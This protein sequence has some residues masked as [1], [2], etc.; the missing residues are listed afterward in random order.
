MS[1]EHKLYREPER[2]DAYVIDGDGNPVGMCFYVGEG[3]ILTCAHVVAEA[4]GNKELAFQDEVPD[5]D[6]S[7]QLFRTTNEVVNA[8]V[9]DDGWFRAYQK[10]DAD[11]D[12]GC[13]D[14]AV[15]E[16]ES[17]PLPEVLEPLSFTDLEPSR[18]EDSMRFYGKTRKKPVGGWVSARENG[19]V[20]KDRLE[21]RT[22]DGEE[23]IVEGGCSG[24][25]VWDAIHGRCVGMIDA[26]KGNRVAYMIQA[27]SLIEACVEI[28]P[29]PPA[30]RA[31]LLQIERAVM[32]ID[33]D[34]EREDMNMLLGAVSQDDPSHPV[35]C[36]I[37][38][39]IEAR[40]ELLLNCFLLESF[41]DGL[42]L[43]QRYA[44]PK[45]VRLHGD[46]D[47]IKRKIADLLCFD[48]AKSAPEEVADHLRN[49]SETIVFYTEVYVDEFSDGEEQ[50]LR[51]YVQY[52]AEI[53][54]HGPNALLFQFF[55]VVTDGP[56]LEQAEVDAV[57][58]AIEQ[59]LSECD[60]GIRIRGP[61]SFGPLGPL[62]KRHLR[63]WV[64]DE[65]QPRVGAA[66]AFDEE[67][68]TSYMLEK[69]PDEFEMN[70]FV[71]FVKQ[72]LDQ[73]IRDA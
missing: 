11:F 70:R 25:L 37:S 28:H 23:N 26:R 1:V 12:A 5:D 39:S 42:G 29:E 71:Y 59:V 33:R 13:S 21:L 14:I 55:Y 68:L 66:P 10:V 62:R 63:R 58:N 65:L 47:R 30:S 41:R 50:T 52:L 51:E 49:R 2:S 18:V 56:K 17:E 40:P 53:A 46:V 44:E 27:D 54:A 57:N 64:K 67:R 4:L 45:E 22:S 8:R 32:L 16:L 15:L 38:G 9:R 7:L 19:S 36:T 24:S 35:I 6:I 73:V 43:N 20:E 61:E 31:L 69:F 48:P 34:D 3:V 60:S 72:K